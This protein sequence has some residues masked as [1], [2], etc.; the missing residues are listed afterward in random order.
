VL[1]NLDN[2]WKDVDDSDTTS[3]WLGT[4]AKGILALAIEV[5]GLRRE[6]YNMKPSDH[7][8]LLLYTPEQS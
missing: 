8:P 1:Y 2:L 7:A 6:L 3:S 4:I 5:R